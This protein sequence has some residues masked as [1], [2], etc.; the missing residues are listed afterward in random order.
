ML[1]HLN[2]HAIADI[3]ETEAFRGILAPFG[4]ITWTAL[5]GGALF[6]QLSRGSLPPD[7]APGAARSPVSARCTRCG[8]SRTAG[9]SRSLRA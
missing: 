9:R 7:R 3:L 8:T 1:E 4:H 6:A 5:L 2:G